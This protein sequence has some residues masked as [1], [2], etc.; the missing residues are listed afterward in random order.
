MTDPRSPVSSAGRDGGPR[1]P[2]PARRVL[3]PKAAGI[4]I[5]SERH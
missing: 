1:F 3:H 4:D 5:G 2:P